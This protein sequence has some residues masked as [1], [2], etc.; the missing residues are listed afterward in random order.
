M[1][2]EDLGLIGNCQLSALVGRTGEIVWACL[3]RFDAE[4]MFA[5]LLDEE[6]GGR[7]AVGPPDGQ[8]GRQSYL[9][10]TNVLS[11]IFRTD[12]GTFRVLDYAPRFQQVEGVFHPAEIHRIIEPLEGQPH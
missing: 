4:P 8:S 9:E 11:T 5:T 2:L 3:P 1:R 7:F 10:N 12:T 6:H